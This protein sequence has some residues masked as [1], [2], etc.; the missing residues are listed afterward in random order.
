MM[1]ES[2]INL[3][4]NSSDREYSETNIS[5]LGTNGAQ[6]FDVCSQQIWKSL[7]LDKKVIKNYN[8]IDGYKLQRIDE[9]VSSYVN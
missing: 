3:I 5:V 7:S 9:A 1:A 6:N 4:G 8:Y 2:A